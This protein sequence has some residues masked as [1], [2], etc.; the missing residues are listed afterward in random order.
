ML[1]SAWDPGCHGDVKRGA[2]YLKY[3]QTQMQKD[4]II[5]SDVYCMSDIRKDAEVRF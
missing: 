5:G 3:Y 2:F 4:S 1:F